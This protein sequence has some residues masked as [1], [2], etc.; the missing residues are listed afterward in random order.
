MNASDLHEPAYECKVYIEKHYYYDAAARGDLSTSLGPWHKRGLLSHLHKTT[1]DKAQ[2]CSLI[3]DAQKVVLDVGIQSSSTTNLLLDFSPNVIRLDIT[4]L[5]LPTLS[6]V[7]L[8]G[9]IASPDRAEDAYLVPLV[10]DLVKTYTQGPNSIILLALPMTNDLAN[11]KGR[12]IV[13]ELGA[14]DRTIAVLTKSDLAQADA[15]Q[16]YIT[17]LRGDSLFGHGYTAVMMD[18]DLSLKCEDARHRETLFF[19]TTQPWSSLEE[20][21]RMRLGLGYLIEHLQ[22]LLTAKVKETLPEISNK[23][24]SRLSEVKAELAEL[25]DVPDLDGLPRV[26]ESLMSRLIDEF[27]QTFLA[28]GRTRRKWNTLATKFEKNVTDSHPSVELWGKNDQKRMKAAR[29][30]QE[31]ESASSKSGKGRDG[32]GGIVEISSDDDDDTNP[33]CDSNNTAHCFELEALRN[34]MRAFSEVG[35]P[36]QPHPQVLEGMIMKSLSDWD[37][38]LQ[39]FMNAV[40]QIINSFARTSMSTV[41]GQYRPFQF[42]TAI[43]NWVKAYLDREIG[44]QWSRAEAALTLEQTTPY[45][46]AFQRST[47]LY[48]Q[49]LA[50]ITESR[51][52]VRLAILQAERDAMRPKRNNRAKVKLD[53][54]D[55]DEFE[56]EIKMVAETQAY[57]DI[58][59]ARFVD[60]ICQNIVA[61]LFTTCSQKLAPALKEWVLGADPR[62]HKL[63]LLDWFAELPEIQQKRHDLSEEREKL[64]EGM[65]YIVHALDTGAHDAGKTTGNGRSVSSPS[66]RSASTLVNTPPST[67]SKRVASGDFEIRPPSSSKRQFGVSKLSIQSSPTPAVKSGFR[68]ATVEDAPENDR[69]NTAGFYL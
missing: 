67:R 7:D 31:S 21:T 29:V 16:Q 39:A 8:P 61:H 33:V 6:F 47:N 57:Y 53:S 36:R 62:Q 50:E 59:A 1:Q 42:Y 46:L 43:T 5:G 32:P 40:S 48:A 14:E 65:K 34:K 19:A 35:I 30:A 63:Q 10:D 41:L 23:V 44:E 26:L 60:N 66:A 3:Q 4:A 68:S 2:I 25:P 17:K 18:P 12:R 27:H 55:A 37:K 24:E 64:T 28:G 49:H 45:T 22:P 13:Q 52:Q 38:N 9:V 20:A 15:Q 54:L 58:A 51:D 56:A 69:D 11:S